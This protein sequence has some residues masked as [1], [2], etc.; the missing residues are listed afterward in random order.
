MNVRILHFNNIH[1]D[2]RT[3][4]CNNTML[5][6]PRKRCGSSYKFTEKYQGNKTNAGDVFNSIRIFK[7]VKF[8]LNVLYFKH[9]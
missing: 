5:Y 1:Y 2:I 3:N 7:I 4:D 9:K 8:L 6:T